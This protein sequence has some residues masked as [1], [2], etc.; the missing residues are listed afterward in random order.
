[1]DGIIYRYEVGNEEQEGW[2]KT[3]QVPVDKVVANLE[4]NWM[5]Q[6]RYKTKGE[7]VGYSATSL[8]PQLFSI[9]ALISFRRSPRADADLLRNG[10][11]S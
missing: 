11:P 9:S 5:K 6:I 8:L 7:K 10:T 4:G 1:M 3:K 2:V